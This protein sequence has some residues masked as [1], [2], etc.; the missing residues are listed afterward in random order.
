MEEREKKEYT[1]ANNGKPIFLINSG[2]TP[3][4][5]GVAAED[6]RHI[7]SSCE[8]HERKEERERDARKLKR[9][10]SKTLWAESLYAPSPLRTHTSPATCCRVVTVVREESKAMN[11]LEGGSRQALR[12][13]ASVSPRTF[14]VREGIVCTPL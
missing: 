13:I 1:Q 2:M 7:C 11:G 10:P 12:W 5:W 9:S 3:R 14:F 8:T 4:P 6:S